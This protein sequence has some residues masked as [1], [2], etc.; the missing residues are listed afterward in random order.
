MACPISRIGGFYRFAVEMI[1][2]SPGPIQG[3]LATLRTASLVKSDAKTAVDVDPV[4]LL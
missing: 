3:A 2:P 1:A 4:A